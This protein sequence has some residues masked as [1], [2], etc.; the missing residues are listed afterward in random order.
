MRSLFESSSSTNK[1]I[2]QLCGLV[3]TETISHEGNDDPAWAENVIKTLAKRLKKSKCLEELAKAIVNEDK[4][5]DCVAIPAEQDKKKTHK[6]ARPHILY[7]KMWR[8]PWLK[9]HHEL[10]A[11]DNCR[12]PFAKKAELICINPFHY[13]PI[14][15]KAPPLPPVVVNKVAGY[16]QVTPGAIAALTN[17]GLA[18]QHLEDR[19]PNAT[20]SV[21][22]MRGHYLSEESSPTSSYMG[23]PTSTSP[24]LGFPGTSS[25]AIPSA[26]KIASRNERF[27]TQNSTSPPPIG[28]TA[29]SSPISP[30]SY[31]SEDR[32]DEHELMDT[33]DDHNHSLTA[34]YLRPTGADMVQELI[35][36]CEPESWMS[37]TYYEEGKRIGDP[38]NVRSHYLLVDGY[39]SPSSEERFC[40]GY[41]DVENRPL[42]VI[43][44]RRQVGRGARFYYIGGEVYCECLSDAA[45][46][47]QS[48]NCNQRHGWH[49]TTVC[50]IPP[51]CNLKI[52]NNAEFAAQLAESVEKGYEA[53]FALTRLCTIRISF[54]KG[55]GADYRRQTIDATPCWIEAHLNGPLQWI[56]RVLRSMG[57]PM[58]NPCPETPP[59]HRCEMPNTLPGGLHPSNRNTID[60]NTK[61]AI[62]Y[63]SHNLLFIIDA[64]TCKRVQ[65][66]DLHSTAIDHVCW[67]PPFS[68]IE[69]SRIE[70]Y[71]IASSD[72]GGQIIISEP[73][74]AS[75]RCQFSH[76]STNVL[77]MKWFV[78]KDMSRDFLLSLHS[79]DTLIL[80]NTDNGEKIWSVSY[81]VPLFDL[82]I[83]PFD[84]C[85]ASFS[86][87]GCNIALCSDISFNN[88]PSSTC[89]TV[90]ICEDQIKSATSIQNLV[91]HNAYRNTLFVVTQSQVHCFHTELFAVLFSMTHEP[92]IIAWL[93]CSSRDAIFSVQAGGAVSLRVGKYS[94]NDERAD[95]QFALERVAFGEIQRQG[96]Q[97]RAVGACLCPVTQS[98]VAV[99]F[100]SGRIVL[101]QLISDKSAV[102]D[103]RQSFIEDY[104]A[105]GSDLET[106]PIGEL[107]I[108]QTGFL[109]ALSSGVSCL[110]MRPI[111]GLGK[112]TDES[113]D[114]ASFKSAH[115]LA[116]GSHA[117]VLHLVDVF[118]CDIVKE[119]AI[120]SSPIKCLEWGGNYTVLT[121]GY[122][123][124]LST[125]HVVKND[126]YAID[127]RTGVKRRIRPEADESPVT[128]L[129]VSYY[130]CYLALAFQREPLEIWDLKGL[131]LLRRMSKTCPL[132]V[133]MAWSSK[134]RA[135]NTT[136]DGGISVYRENLVVLDSETRLYHVVVKGLHVKDGKE[137]NTQWKSGGWS[138][139]NMAWKDEMLA[140][141]DAEGRI[142]IWDLGRRQSRHV[143]ASRFPVVR[144]T[145]SRLAGDHTLAV[146]HPRELSLWDTEALTR[147]YQITL[148][149]TRSA[150]DMDL[151][152]VSPILLTN[153]N[154]LR[155]APSP[156]KNTPM[157]EKDI[158][159]LLNPKRI[160]QLKSDFDSS[161]SEEPAIWKIAQRK[162]HQAP[163]PDSV[164]ISALKN[165]LLLSRFLGDVSV[166][167]LLE[168]ICSVLSEE[169]NQLPPNL[170]LYWPNKTFRERELR[171]TCAACSAGNI[172]ESR[173]VERA[174]VAGGKAK[175]RAVDRLIG[176]N[177]L[178]HASMKAALLVSSQES[179]QA[180]SL[181]KL[182]ATNLI[183][184]DMIED[185]VELL[186]LVKAGA[187]AC[188]YLQ[189]QRQWDKSIVYA[190]MGL[191][192]SEDVLSKWITYLSFD[193][194]TPY[195]YAQAS[196]KEWP[197]IVELLSNC[198][199]AEL[200]RMILR[201]ST[202]SPPTSSRDAS[203]PGASGDG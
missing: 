158:P 69:Q 202:S 30:N 70:D 188:K 91:Y 156:I 9:S 66:I 148:D 81:N 194:K 72:I 89:R 38:F 127:I 11:V 31:L 2:A 73:I 106:N 183:A 63:G 98:S 37:I 88:T 140:M 15:A 134:H 107:S 58:E 93:C 114:L 10:K 130:Q 137:V 49:P 166:C 105:F 169:G 163:A 45:V 149:T 147:Q 20:I 87:L 131:R 112:E 76:A 75:K 77:S 99:L 133:D 43:D 62:V 125:A 74:S 203:S 48:P 180:R 191:E 144:M 195:M 3:K 108:Q 189:S 46:F 42:T 23:S 199:H 170:Q 179:E 90:V 109:D 155:Y 118:T 12:Y 119:F 13:E 41:F 161:S 178:R 181:I 19:A 33:S 201:A 152:G 145:F 44:A 138:I 59:S 139:R 50:K 61:G 182:I 68:I 126:I 167:N 26:A 83:D 184:S 8:F 146:L 79:G 85:H 96:N 29:A 95:A 28:S 157:L 111:D 175:E 176:S 136:E 71:R 1:T 186:F 104:L 67:S 27:S 56:D 174:V 123:H 132:I 198:G 97:Q 64:F 24:A 21:D 55:W 32:D 153:D 40:L 160:T 164:D 196:R 22:E 47:V 117:G 34:S 128:L 5:T 17:H 193:E 57:A 36:Y 35:E 168:I 177:D 60:W 101:W 52:F 25:S 135:M 100:N 173:L 39:P 185:G 120:Q 121:A 129:R 102:L 103:Y 115:I 7:I 190:K 92:N 113:L 80:W 110:R 124:S 143:R 82:A 142:I 162:V 197:E 4:F 94:S 53:V 78:W 18:A 200:A 51:N 86:S 14:H 165:K 151:C 172:E 16:Y 65:T 6:K 84:P 116:V 192:D 141:G 150:L 54:V 154:V 187:D 122:N 159:L 171:V